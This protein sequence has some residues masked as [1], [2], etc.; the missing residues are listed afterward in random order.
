MT[1]VD[2]VRPGSA[3]ADPTLQAAWT[4]RLHELQAAAA[5]GGAKERKRLECAADIRSILAVY[6]W[7]RLN[8]RYGR[9]ESAQT[10]WKAIITLDVWEAYHWETNDRTFQLLDPRS[11]QKLGE[12]LARPGLLTMPAGTLEFAGDPASIGV[13]RPSG[14]AVDTITLGWCW[15]L[16]GVTLR[17]G[18]DALRGG[19]DRLPPPYRQ[20][21]LDLHD[22]FRAWFVDEPAKPGR[23]APNSKETESYAAWNPGSPVHRPRFGQQRGGGDQ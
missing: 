9:W 12:L 4:D 2:P 18:I 19:A 16:N 21:D 14:G 11:G 22:K 13:Y 7:Q 6:P 15:L 20:I 17:K 8:Y 5:A 23:E 10:F 1:P 3:L